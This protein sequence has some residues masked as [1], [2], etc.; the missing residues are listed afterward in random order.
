MSLNILNKYNF[1]SLRNATTYLIY[2]DNLF[3]LLQVFF[4]NT[5]SGPP[6]VSMMT[7]SGIH[8]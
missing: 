6:Q 2:Q 7:L 4:S 8:W 5:R 3:T 1:Y